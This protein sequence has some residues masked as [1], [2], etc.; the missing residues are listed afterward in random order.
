MWK[1]YLIQINNLF[2]Q[3]ARLYKNYSK[4]YDEYI[5]THK[6]YK[7][8]DAEYVA[9]EK[10]AMTLDFIRFYKL[11]PNKSLSTS[12]LSIYNKIANK[13]KKEFSFEAMEKVLNELFN[14]YIPEFPKQV[15]L[16][17][18]SLKLPKLVKNG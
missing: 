7:G 11:K 5:Q 4:L 1:I 8:K 17:L 16:K 14:K 13:N 12:L 18:P 9:E 6:N 2:Q 10:L 3:Y 15:E